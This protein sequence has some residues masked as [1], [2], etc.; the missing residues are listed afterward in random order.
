[1]GK[2]AL[3]TGG[4]SGIGLEI[5][6]QLAARNYRVLTC[7][8][9][10]SLPPLFAGVESVEYLSC[11]L[12]AASGAARLIDWVEECTPQLDALFNNAGIQNE[13]L[14]DPSLRWAEADREIALNLTAP[15]AIAAALVPHLSRASGTVV[16][17]SSGLALAPK[18]KSPVYCA[19]KAGLSSFSRTLRYQMEERGVRVVDVVTPLVKTPMTAGRNDKALEPQRFV[20]EMLRLIERGHD[21]VY[22]G[23]AKLLSVLMR[24]APSRARRI[25]RSA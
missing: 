1:M 23:K 9:R 20:T 12:S 18:A 4:T 21:E 8:S 15:I 2:T 19:T 22:V 3:V 24:L 25:M 10:E 6:S 11:D 16:N 13:C 5:V 17:L 14:I 7:G